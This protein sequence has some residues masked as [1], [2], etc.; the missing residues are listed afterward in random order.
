VS[1]SNIRAFPS[2]LRRSRA[3]LPRPESNEEAQRAS[4]SLAGD[5]LRSAAGKDRAVVM[6]AVGRF[7]GQIE[8][9]TG[10]SHRADNFRLIEAAMNAP[11]DVRNS[12]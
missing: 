3:T 2:G 8:T 9:I 7:L 6:A 11:M 5:F 12:D 4:I 1:V 10:S